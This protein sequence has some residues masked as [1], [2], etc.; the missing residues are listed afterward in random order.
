MTETT[1]AP[2]YDPR[3]IESDIYRRW[4]ESGAFAARPDSGASPTSS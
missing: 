1:L 2:Q 3:A 4:V